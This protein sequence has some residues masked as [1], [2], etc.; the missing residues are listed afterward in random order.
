MAEPYIGEIRMVGFNFAPQGWA[1][2]DGSLLSIADYSTLFTLIGT[3]YGGDGQN[4]F[5]L[6]NLK[7]CVPVHQGSAAGV[8]Y[9]MGQYMGAEQVTLAAA[10]M[11]AHNHLVP[12]SASGNTNNPAN[13]YFGGDATAKLYASADGSAQ[14]NNGFL[15]TTGG[16]QPHSNMMPYLVINFVIA[17]FGV[18]PSQS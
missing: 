16:N 10:Q 2:C 9:T 15:S 3:T 6:P 17:L 7:G 13:G 5:A 11:P 1:F 8:A 12:C 18:Y 14:L 4:T